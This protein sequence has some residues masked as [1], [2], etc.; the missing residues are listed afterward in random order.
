VNDKTFF[1][2]LREDMLQTRHRRFQYQLTKIASIGFLIGVATIVI[3]KTDLPLFYYVIPFIA[4]AFDFFILSESFT[5]RRMAAFIRYYKSEINDVEFK[6]EEF[7]KLNPDKMASIAN[8]IVTLSCSIGCFLILLLTSHSPLSW[9]KNGMNL[10]WLLAM[11][12]CIVGVGLVEIAFSKRAW[13]FEK[14]VPRG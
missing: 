4:I 3:E 12:S 10:I 11:I 1:E 5:M 8:K 9:I 7:V 2:K 14:D 6:W 13:V